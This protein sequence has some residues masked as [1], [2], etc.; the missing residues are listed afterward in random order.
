MVYLWAISQTLYYF[1][2]YYLIYLPGN[3]YENT[4]ASGAAE[5]AGTLIGG[6]LINVVNAR[7]AFFISNLIALAGGLC[8]LLIGTSQVAWMPAFVIIAKLGVSSTYILVYA[9]TI[10]LFPTLF[11]AT[12]FGACAV[13]ASTC[14]IIS[15][16][17]AQVQDPYPMLIFCIAT[18]AG[19]VISFLIILPKRSIK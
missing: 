9:V 1:M 11:A 13:M 16:Y 3:T 15:P 6:F 2:S 19:A 8:I 18:G 4:Y 7:W 5:V 17:I 12:A 14:A 10:D